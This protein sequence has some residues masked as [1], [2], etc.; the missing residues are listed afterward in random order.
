MLVPVQHNENRSDL[1]AGLGEGQIA[2]SVA[3]SRAY[4]RSMGTAVQLSSVDKEERE[5][6]AARSTRVELFLHQQG[7]DTLT[8]S[9]R[10]R[11]M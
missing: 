4:R 8:P 7:L 5:L 10:A 3:E 1:A 2:E 6:R 11:K 9:G